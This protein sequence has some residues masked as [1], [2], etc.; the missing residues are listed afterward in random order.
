M[1]YTL[2]S[3]FLQEQIDYFKNKISDREILP[4]IFI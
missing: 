3:I 2:N 1:N 4:D